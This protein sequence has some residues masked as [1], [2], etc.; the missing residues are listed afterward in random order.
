MVAGHIRAAA[1]L[2]LLGDLLPREVTTRV[3]VQMDV[4]LI[5]Y[6]GT[7]TVCLG[8]FTIDVIVYFSTSDL[9][10]VRFRCVYNNG[11]YTWY[12]LC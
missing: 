2:Q 7:Y 1:C 10:N 9:K 3:S 8:T 6:L 5:V 12:T 4:R 11:I